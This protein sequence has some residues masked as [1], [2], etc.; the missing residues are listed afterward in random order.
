M[1]KHCVY[2]IDWEFCI[3]GRLILACDFYNIQEI[4]CV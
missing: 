4:E 3:L 2:Y 1:I